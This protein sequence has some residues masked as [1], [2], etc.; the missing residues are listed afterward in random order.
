MGFGKEP[1]IVINGET[2]TR[3]EALTVRMAVASFGLSLQELPEP[4][5]TPAITEG[6]RLSITRIPRLMQKTA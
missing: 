5:P 4:D 1:K 3:A 6:Y 2:L